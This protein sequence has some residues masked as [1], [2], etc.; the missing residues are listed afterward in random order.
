MSRSKRPIAS[1]KSKNRRLVFGPLPKPAGA[2]TAPYA[3]DRPE[4]KGLS[5]GGLTKIVAD[6]SAFK[7]EIGAVCEKLDKQRAN[8]PGP[9]PLYTALECELVLLYQR[10]CGLRAYSEARDRL[11]SDRGIE[12]RRLFGLNRPRDINVNRKRSLRS[13]IPSEATVSRHRKR[14]GERRRRGAYERFFKKIVQEHLINFPEMREEARLL[15]LDGSKLETHFTCPIYDGDRLV[16]EHAVTCPDGGYVGRGAG[17][18]KSGHGFNQLTLTA[19]SGLPLTGALLPLHHGESTAAIEL[20]KRELR[21]DVLPYLA[22]DK[23]HVLV[24]DGAFHRHELRREIRQ[25]GIVEQIHNVSHGDSERSTENARKH[26]HLV[27]EIDGYP[28]WHSNGHYEISCSCGEGTVAKRYRLK[29]ERVVISSEGKCANCGPITITAGRWRKVQNYKRTGQ[30]AFVRCQ[31]DQMDE[32]DQAFGNPLTFND[33]LSEFY[34][35][36]RFAHG[37]GLHGTLVSRF[38]LLKGKRWFRRADQAKTD[39]AMVFSIMHALSMEQRRR[40]AANAAAAGSSPPTA[41]A[42]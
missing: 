27:W 40:A 32:A 19:L 8:K 30:T 31:P 5:C 28:N 3:K 12:A 13:G 10:V 15:S 20:V 9:K 14:F 16:N 35:W 17:A 1:G 26:D 2:I 24:A 11:T 37:E 36:K 38:G 42:A 41:L 21:R 7:S 18:D 23:H 22:R 4:L 6:S 29:A 39:V 33:P 34:G 25:A